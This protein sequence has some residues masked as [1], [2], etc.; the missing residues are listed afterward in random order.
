L[1][2]ANIELLRRVPV[3]Q[4]QFEIGVQ[5]TSTDTLDQVGRKSNLKRLFHNVARLRTE[6]GIIIHLDLVAG[7]PGEDFPGF[8]KS[9]QKL[10]D[11]R[12]HHIQVEPLKVLKGSPM[13][14]LAAEKSYAFSATPPYTI[15]RTPW[16][17]YEEIGRIDTIS[18]LLDLYYNSVRFPTTLRVVA[19]IMPLAEFFTTFAAAWEKEPHLDHLRPETLAER[20]R[21]F[22]FAQLQGNYAEIYDA[23]RFDL[24]SAEY[25]PASLAVFFKDESKQMKKESTPELSRRL[26]IPAGSRIRTFS[27]EFLHNYSTEP[28]GT[29]P[30]VLTFVYASAPQRGL[31][32]S[33]VPT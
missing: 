14:Q 21:A 25:P 26:A 16:L 32:V 19:A 20:L 9:F 6:T 17:T 30:A 3:G 11:A 4:F 2:D 15:L 18:R 10:L 31:S 5:S 13:R 23:L 22:C 1:T 24:C 12:P 8:E 29:A 28:W 7:L 27:A 33:I